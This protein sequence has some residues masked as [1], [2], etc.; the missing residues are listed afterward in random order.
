MCLEWFHHKET[1]SDTS[2][3][4]N[5]CGLNDDKEVFIILTYG[6]FPKMEGPQSHHRLQS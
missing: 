2:G 1:T 6:A 5:V 4:K 3:K